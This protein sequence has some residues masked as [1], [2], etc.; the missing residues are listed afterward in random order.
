MVSGSILSAL[1]L[2]ILRC[3]LQF[4][5]EERKHAPY[6]VDFVG[7]YAKKSTGLLFTGVRMLMNFWPNSNH[8]PMLDY[9]NTLAKAL[10][11]SPVTPPVTLPQ[12]QI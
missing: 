10:S 5:E 3:L 7:Y 1:E 6:S 4:S 9:L 2:F 12:G 8:F 11:S